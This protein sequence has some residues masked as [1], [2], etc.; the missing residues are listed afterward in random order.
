MGIDTVPL[1]PNNIDLICD[2]A[3][4]YAKATIRISVR[5]RNKE[6]RPLNICE[7]CIKE[8]FPN[9]ID[10]KNSFNT[11]PI[12]IDDKDVPLNFDKKTIC[13]CHNCDN[14]ADTFLEIVRLPM[15]GYYCGSCAIDIKLHGIAKEVIKDSL[16]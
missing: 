3:R 13:T 14:E 12:L 1:D 5:L 4:C 11:E 2:A 16:S 8:F 9:G 10:I 7:S 15:S 6:I